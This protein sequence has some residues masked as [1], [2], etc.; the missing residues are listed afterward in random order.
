MTTRLE[1]TWSFPQYTSYSILNAINPAICWQSP[2]NNPLVRAFEVQM[3]RTEEELWVSL[4]QTGKNYAYVDVDD[5]DIKSSY[6]IRI[7]TIGLNGKRSGWSY[8]PRY[9]ASPLRFDFSAVNSIRLPSGESK[10][11]QRLLFLL[12]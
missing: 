1:T 10:P 11:N 3:L 5:Y 8:S 4:G 6:Q 2:I 12:F 7:A 9:I